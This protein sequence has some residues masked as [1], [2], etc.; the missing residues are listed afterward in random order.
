MRRPRCLPCVHGSRGPPVCGWWTSE[1]PA[2]AAPL[3]RQAHGHRP[4]VTGA[5]TLGCSL[6]APPSSRL[7]PSRSPRSERGYRSERWC[8]ALRHVFPI[9]GGKQRSEMD[10]NQKGAQWS[11]PPQGFPGKPGTLWT[12]GRTSCPR[13][14]HQKRKHHKQPGPQFSPTNGFGFQ[15]PGR[16]DHKPWGM[17]QGRVC[18]RK[19]REM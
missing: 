10:K 3:Q 7:G 12:S 11:S 14:H 19:A 4:W 15:G 5:V 1:A 16:K 2:R 18:R 9:Q 13:S 6:A 8:R 17:G